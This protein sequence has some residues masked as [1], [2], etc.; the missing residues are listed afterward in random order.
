MRRSRRTAAI[1]I[2]ACLAL[3]TPIGAAS[4]TA[5][6]GGRPGDQ[7]KSA[8]G[9]NILV[10]GKVS[11]AKTGAAA[12]GTTVTLYAWPS[13]DVSGQLKVGDMVDIQR[14]TSATVAAD[15][16]FQLAMESLD[17]LS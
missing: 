16:S 8:T 3:M 9:E 2:A 6:A 5:G 1:S 12:V 15:G 17:A 14:L 11:Q 7:P 4:A 13:N 10:T